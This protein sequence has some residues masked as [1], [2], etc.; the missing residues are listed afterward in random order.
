M[1]DI[2][3]EKQKFRQWWIWVI[4]IPI[5]LLFI[6][7]LYRQL[8]LGEDFG[9]NPM[10]DFALISISAFLFLLSYF[11]WGTRLKLKIDRYHIQIDFFPFIRKKIKWGDVQ[12]AKLIDYGFVGYGMRMGGKHGTVYN[13]KGRMGLAIELKNGKKLVIGSQKPKELAVFIDQLDHSTR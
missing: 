5:N 2:Y 9:N 1:I 7:G 13:I 3:K 11:F 6:L 4:L 10:P 8:I 12:S